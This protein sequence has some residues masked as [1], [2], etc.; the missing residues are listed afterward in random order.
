MLLL[1]RAQ[2]GAILNAFAAFVVAIS[3][4]GC[5]EL[6]LQLRDQWEH[7]MTVDGE[8]VISA[9]VVLRPARGEPPRGD[10]AVTSETIQQFMPSTEAV[11]RAVS[12]FQG[13][14]FQVGPLAGNNFSITADEK[15]FERVFQTEF[16]RRV[17]GGVETVRGGGLGDLE[18]PV[19]SIPDSLG[20]VIAS[21][22]FS[23]PPDFGPSNY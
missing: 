11:N 12:F 16:R 13:A 22:T 5:T 4:S 10:T 15:T 23:P 2:S 19:D 17:D 8:Q 6:G 18:L 7:V 9:Q 14:G 20:E 1:H 21:V 3:F